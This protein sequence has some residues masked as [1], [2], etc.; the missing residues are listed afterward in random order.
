MKE[1]QVSSHNK[2]RNERK[3]MENLMESSDAERN[4]KSKSFEQ[5]T[6]WLC[7]LGRVLGITRT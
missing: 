2:N 4:G 6:L 5:V 3:T 1:R 7:A